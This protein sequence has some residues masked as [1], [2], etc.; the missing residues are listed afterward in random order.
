MPA[1]NQGLSPLTAMQKVMFVQRFE[2]H[3]SSI[4][5]AQSLVS[6]NPT[7]NARTNPTAK[8]NINI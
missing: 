5:E 8:K 2:V 6:R 7:P 1:Q 4:D 3:R